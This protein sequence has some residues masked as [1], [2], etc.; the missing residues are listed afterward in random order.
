LSEGNHIKNF[1]DFQCSICLNIFKDPKMCSSCLNIFCGICIDD[2]IAKNNLNFNINN[3]NNDFYNNSS[4]V[5]CRK[6]FIAAGI[7]KS[8]MNTIDKLIYKCPNF[9]MCRYENN[10]F[11]VID[12][13]LNCDY[14]KRKIYC[15]SCYISIEVLDPKQIYNII[16]NHYNQCGKIL[17]NCEFCELVVLREELDKHKLICLNRREKCS[18]C[19]FNII[20]KDLESHLKNECF[21]KIKE[22]YEKL[23]NEKNVIIED[24]K[25]ENNLLKNKVYFLSF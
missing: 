11:R 10:H 18:I 1:E 5:N 14:N 9:L 24:L 16:F 15:K 17:V 12:H 21:F 4:C 22:S 2:W 25:N 3:N 23:I 19:S 6:T 20:F 13:I 8:I 7:P